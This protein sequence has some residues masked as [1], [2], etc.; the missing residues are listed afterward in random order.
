MQHQL[1]FSLLLTM[2]FFILSCGNKKNKD[3]DKELETVVFD[4]EAYLKSEL[5][6]ASLKRIEDFRNLGYDSVVYQQ[7]LKTIADYVENNK[8]ELLHTRNGIVY[9]VTEKGN[10]KVPKEGDE[11]HVQVETTD[12]EGDTLFSTTQLGQYLEFILGKGQVVP[13][14]DQLFGRLEEGSKVTIISPSA[15]SY[16]VRGVTKM[17]SKNIILKYDITVLKIIQD[18]SN[19][20]SKDAPKL[21]VKKDSAK[22]KSTIHSPKTK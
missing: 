16:G 15:L 1:S 13:A 21:E 4:T 14:W 12:L 19:A 11:L 6:E 17:V 7:D 20:V 2:S 3:A 18:E 8:N 9:Y 22:G 5:G 10:G